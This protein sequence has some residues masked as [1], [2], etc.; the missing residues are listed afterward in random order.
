M[1]TSTEKRQKVGLFQR[2]FQ[3]SMSI[4]PWFPTFPALSNFYSSYSSMPEGEGNGSKGREGDEAAT[5]GGHGA[6]ATA[7]AAA[8][9][10]V[11]KVQKV[12][13]MRLDAPELAAALQQLSEFYGNSL[14]GAVPPA[15]A[16]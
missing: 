14:E 1:A 3:P 13:E 7:P 10:I 15:R 5:P 11:K 2:F 4:F 6:G 12:V 8:P 16:P 9:A